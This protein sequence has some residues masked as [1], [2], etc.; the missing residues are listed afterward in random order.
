ME[1]LIMVRVR[2]TTAT[3]SFNKIQEWPT[4]EAAVESYTQQNRADALAYVRQLHANP[5]NATIRTSRY[6][7]MVA[8]L[9]IVEEVQDA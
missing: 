4:F 6:L 3:G 5:H 7:E 9:Y 1:V 2:I 8:P